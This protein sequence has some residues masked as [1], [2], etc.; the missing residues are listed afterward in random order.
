MVLVEELY[1]IHAENLHVYI[2]SRYYD[3]EPA[4]TVQAVFLKLLK[5]TNPPTNGNLG[6]Y[7]CRMADSEVMNRYRRKSNRHV[8]EGADEQADDH[9]ELWETITPEQ[10][11]ADRHE[12]TL[13][14]AALEKMPKYQRK[15][16]LMYGYGD[17]T[18][19]EIARRLGS[20]ERKVRRHV[21]KAMADL[22][23][24]ISELKTEDA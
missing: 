2:R 12:L 23:R 15:L 9:P 3:V 21:S 16:V 6:A 11:A 20:P 5:M 1:R 7:L 22:Q 17:L 10:I 4:E 18:C 14:I 24:L 8:L 19:A 13:A